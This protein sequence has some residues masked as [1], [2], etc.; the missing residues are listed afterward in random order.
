MFKEALKKLKCSFGHDWMIKE[1][2][3]KYIDVNNLQTDT[4][5]LCKQCQKMKSI[6]NLYPRFDFVES[7]PEEKKEET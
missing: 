6:T 1:E 2:N 5:F 4:T 7:K 3:T